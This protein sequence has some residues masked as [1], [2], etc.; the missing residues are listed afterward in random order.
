MDWDDPEAARGRIARLLRQAGW[1]ALALLA[2]ALPPWSARP[3]GLFGLAG[4]RFDWIPAV[5]SAHPETTFSF[6][7]MWGGALAAIFALA[8]A[9]LWRP[10]PSASPQNPEL[11]RAAACVTALACGLLIL[12]SAQAIREDLLLEPMPTPPLVFAGCAAAGLLMLWRSANPASNLARGLVLL[13]A[14]AMLAIHAAAIPTGDGGETILLWRHRFLMEFGKGQ[15]PALALFSLALL[16]LSLSSLLCLPNWPNAHGMARLWGWSFLL[17]PHLYLLFEGFLF[18]LQQARPGALLTH[19][20]IALA[21]ALGAAIAAHGWMA[22]ILRLRQR[23][24]GSIVQP[25][26]VGDSSSSGVRGGAAS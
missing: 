25:T 5:L 9:G 18:L 22:L 17:Y 10:R 26:S 7:M 12:A 2:L 15:Y 3:V 6:G 21:G 20:L 1:M 24:T 23:N 8:R 16:P 19:V 4:E 13:I 14:L 11:P